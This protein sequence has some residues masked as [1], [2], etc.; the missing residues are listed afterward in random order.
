MY[1]YSGNLLFILSYLA[2]VI[3]PRIPY[4][5]S[6][7]LIFRMLPGNFALEYFE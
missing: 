1:V 6:L 5:F 3:L 2:L 4:N 7:L